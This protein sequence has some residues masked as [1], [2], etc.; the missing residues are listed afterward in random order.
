MSSTKTPAVTVPADAMRS[1][2]NLLRHAVYLGL[3][4]IVK[5]CSIPMSNYARY[6]VL[7]LFA[8]RI[9]S[10][11]IADGVLIWFP[12]KVRIGRR[13]SL[14]QGVIIDGFGGVTIGDGV[15]I[16]AYAVINTADHEF[17]DP[18]CM[19]CDQGF[20]VAPVV[21]EDDVWIGTGAVIGKGV[22]VGR[23][24]VIGAGAVVTRDIPPDSVAVG[25]PARVIR[26][27]RTQAT[28]DMPREE[29]P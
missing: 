24:S 2:S 12:W 15:R 13:T 17:A 26:N 9:D 22:R 7:K 11:Y 6:F 3:Y 10:S 23:G 19:I 28:N 5:H 27:R 25:L 29:S 4:G 8:G 16:A 21:I 20:V 18:D 14:N 1:R